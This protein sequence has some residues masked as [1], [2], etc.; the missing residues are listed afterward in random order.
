[1]ALRSGCVCAL[2][3]INHTPFTSHDLPVFFIETYF[4]SKGEGGQIKQTPS[5]SP[6]LHIVL[7]N[8]NA[9][10]MS[11]HLLSEIS[12]IF[13]VE[14]RRW[15]RKL[16]CST[17]SWWMPANRK[18]ESSCTTNESVSKW[19]GKKQ[20]FFGENFDY[21]SYFILAELLESLKPNKHS[22]FLIMNIICASCHTEMRINEQ[23]HQ[24]YAEWQSTEPHSWALVLNSRCS[25]SCWRIGLDIKFF[26]CDSGFRRPPKLRRKH[27]SSWSCSSAESPNYSFD[28]V[29]LAV[30]RVDNSQN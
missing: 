29:F 6:C 24:Q 18:C 21:E 20:Q 9:S 30:S 13:E 5:S 23:Q 15:R 10:E 16:C 28:L 17:Q 8:S 19:Q 25:L 2:T 22:N 4:I 14:E 1:M 7:D 12:F 26:L 11:Q 3:G 27:Q